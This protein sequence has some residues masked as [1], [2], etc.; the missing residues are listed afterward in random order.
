M[1]RR[2]FLSLLGGAAVSWPVEAR[3]QQPA[4]PVVGF[5]SITAATERP[6]RLAAF[7]QGLAETGLAEGTNVNIEY[8]WAEGRYDRFPELVTDLVRRQV[9][10]IVA[11]GN[12]PAPLAAKTATTTIPIVFA[13]SG[14]PVG[15]GLV[16][17]LNRP[18][19]NLT[20]INFFTAE[21]VA[22]RLG[23]LRELLPFARHVA[24]LANPTDP[25]TLSAVTDQAQSA[26][27]LLDLD[28][29]IISAADS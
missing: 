24:V 7:R 4:M 1:R 11:P 22:K 12:A 23:V 26:A 28:V 29:R 8:R 10:V 25:N 15:L 3:A 16:A 19:G 21:L 13:V 27:R 5:L 9:A 14:D 20:G 2:E 18:G 17:S 6:D